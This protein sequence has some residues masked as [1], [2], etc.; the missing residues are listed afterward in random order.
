MLQTLG[1]AYKTAQLRGGSI[2]GPE[3]FYLATR[4]SARALYLDDR[5]GSLAPGMEADLIVLDLKSTS[6]IEYRMRTCESLAEA[7][8]VQ[9]TMGDDRAVESTYVAGRLAHQR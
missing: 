7:L 6:A 2:S 3:G 8:F 5:I 9:M 1:G 4:G